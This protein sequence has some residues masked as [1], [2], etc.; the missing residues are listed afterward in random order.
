MGKPRILYIG[1]RDSD[2]EKMQR[3]G[4]L[5]TSLIIPEDSSNFDAIIMN[6][7]SDK[8]IAEIEHRLAEIRKQANQTTILVTGITQGRFNALTQ[9]N[10]V[11]YGGYTCD[12]AYKKAQEII[13]R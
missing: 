10:K 12:L 9:N 5:E 2:A 7:S 8:P 4:K 11:S 6:T 13:L 3:E 1:E